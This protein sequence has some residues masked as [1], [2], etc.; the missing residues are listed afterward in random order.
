M[1]ISNKWKIWLFLV[2]SIVLFKGYTYTIQAAEASPDDSYTETT[3]VNIQKQDENNQPI[4]GAQLQIIDQN[5]QVKETWTTDGTNHETSLEPGTYTLHEQ[6][7]PT[8][9]ETSKDIVFTV[10]KPT[11]DNQSDLIGYH[12]WGLHTDYSYR[13]RTKDQSPEDGKIVYCL[14][15]HR[16]YPSNNTYNENDGIG[17]DLKRSVAIDITDIQA[18]QTNIKRVLYYGYGSDVL[19]LQAQYKMTSNAFRKVTQ[20]AIWYYSDGQLVNIPDTPGSHGSYMIYHLLVESDLA[21]PNNIQL[22]LYHPDDPHY[23]NL[24]GFVLYEPLTITMIDKTKTVPVTPEVPPTPTRSYPSQ[25]KV[26]DV[27]STHGVQT[28]VSQSVGS[29]LFVSMIALFG[30]VAILKKQIR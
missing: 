2:C 20:A 24:V 25:P 10:T 13:V 12:Y 3:G 21:V 4:Q 15:E 7:A 1:K 18:F 11:T 26:T 8:G 22:K 19:G 5:N 14:N 29:Y 17:A 28:G 30:F 6:Q 23:Q 9:Y 16:T 27:R